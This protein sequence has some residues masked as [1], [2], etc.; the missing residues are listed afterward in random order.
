M[1][2]IC[3]TAKGRLYVYGCVYMRVPSLGCI[4]ERVCILVITGSCRATSITFWLHDAEV[5]VWNTLEADGR[6]VNSTEDGR[7][8]GKWIG[9]I[10][11]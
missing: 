9:L 10:F 8:G 2:F 3:G 6:S 1:G 5:A 4:G 7:E 11:H